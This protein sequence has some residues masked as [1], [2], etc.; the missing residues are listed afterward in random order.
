MPSSRMQSTRIAAS[1]KNYT[2]A[3]LPVIVELRGDAYRLVEY[4][5][6][7]AAAAEEDRAL[8]RFVRKQQRVE[9]GPCSGERAFFGHA[10]KT[11]W[12]S[13]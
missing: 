9:Q 1:T 6:D 13:Q 3:L 11:T 12:Q 10:V 5:G 2:E 8:R 7:K 4:I